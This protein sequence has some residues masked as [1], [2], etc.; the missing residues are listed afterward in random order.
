MSLDRWAGDSERCFWFGFSASS[1][2]PIDAIMNSCPPDLTP[3]RTV[4]NSGLRTRNG[5][6][7]F[8]TPLSEE[9][10]SRPVLGRYPNDNEFYFGKYDLRSPSKLPELDYERARDFFTRVFR[11]RLL[12]TESDPNPFNPKGIPDACERAMQSIKVRRGQQKF[13]DKL[14]DAYGRQCAVSG[15]NVVDVLEAAHITPFLG[16]KTNHITNGLLLRAD[17]H[18]LLDC[19]SHLHCP[20]HPHTRRVILTKGLHNSPDYKDLHDRRLR[21]PEPASK[22]PTTAV[23]QEAIRQRCSWFP[24]DAPYP[25]DH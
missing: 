21:A 24:L 9:E 5:Y 2:K 19:G 14:L 22:G 12:P 16:G 15:C 20:V 3:G 7:C 17:L 6:W 1:S 18:T 8:R 10:A 11:P 4:A 13:R 23:L 25:V